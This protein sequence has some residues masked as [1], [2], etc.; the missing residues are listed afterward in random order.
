MSDPIPLLTDLELARNTDPSLPGYRVAVQLTVPRRGPGRLD[1]G[2]IRGRGN[3]A[4]ALVVR[5]LTPVGEL[6]ELGH[7]RYGSRLH[8]LVGRRNTENVRN[9]VRLYVLEA[10]EADPRVAEVTRLVVGRR[11]DRPTV[12]DVEL[13]V[14][15]VESAG[16]LEVGPFSLELSP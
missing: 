16:I 6:E 9:L 3:L 13:A 15:P 8:E 14:R 4:Q 5:L 12:V 11:P 2:L 7:P 10:V 1:P